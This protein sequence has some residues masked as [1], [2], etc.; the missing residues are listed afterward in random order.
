VVRPIYASFGF[1]GLSPATDTGFETSASHAGVDEDSSVQN[2]SELFN[3]LRKERA[4]DKGAS[5]N[6]SPVGS[7]II[8][9]SC[10]RA[11]S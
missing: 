3:S 10:Y 6:A 9:H 2:C 5:F 11:A 8:L 1:K 4:S 7:D